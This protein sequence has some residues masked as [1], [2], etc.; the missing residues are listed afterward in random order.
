M[1]QAGN[2]G[3]VGGAHGAGG[4]VWFAVPRGGA[5]PAARRP[6]ARRPAGQARRGPLAA[7]RR[8]RGGAQARRDRASLARSA[9][10]AEL[11]RELPDEDFGEHLEDSVALYHGGSKPYAE[12][13]EYLDLV[14]DALDRVG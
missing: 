12:E 6:A 1:G 5:E 4:V 3:V 8:W 10:V 7:W 11:A 9:V 2:A 13:A 14:E